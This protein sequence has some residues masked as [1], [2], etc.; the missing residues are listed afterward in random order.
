ME[1][2]NAVVDGS[3]EEKDKVLINMKSKNLEDVTSVQVSLGF[4][5][6]T[7]FVIPLT[8]FQAYC[9][10]RLLGIQIKDGVVTRFTDKDLND[11]VNNSRG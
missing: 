11:F 3:V 5:D 8:E 1:N 9:L 2:V 10:V 6:D 7:G 4:G